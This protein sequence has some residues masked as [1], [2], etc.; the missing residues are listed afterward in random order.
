[1]I[2]ARA[3][4][5]AAIALTLSACALVRTP[6]PATP[7]VADP[8]AWQERRE[9]LKD[10]D[11]WS[12]QG[13]AATGKLLGW[14]GNLSWRQEGETFDVR[15]SGPL[16]AGGFRA[17]GEPGLVR[18]YT[19]DETYYT[20]EPEAMVEEIV[21]WRFPLE[22]LR[23]WAIGLP[24]P[25]LPA[26]LSVDDDGLLT[27]LYQSGWQLAYTEYQRTDG[28]TL[29]RRIVLNNGDD[30]IKLVIDRW[31]DLETGE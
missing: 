12:L 29:P 31:F 2:R 19:G 5:L 27:G 20:N 23:Y 4:V 18:I 21:G 14:S 26:R 22:G 16:G 1:M 6:P 3:F 24:A 28:F 13:R 30:T 17:R 9:L 8:K 7:G 15:L 11:R 10:F 25:N